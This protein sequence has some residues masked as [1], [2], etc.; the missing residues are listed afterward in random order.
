MAL[1]T[2]KERKELFP[3]FKTCTYLNTASTG[4]VPETAIAEQDRFM[5]F[6]R[7]ETIQSQPETFEVIE[8]IREKLSLILGAPA[9]DIALIN[10]TSYGINMTAWG[11]DFQKGDK[12]LIPSNEFPANF[13]PWKIHESRGAEIIINNESDEAYFDRKDAKVIAP[14]WIRFYDGF[15]F[16]LTH[17]VDI[18]KK[19]NSLVCVDGIQGAGV[20][21]PDLEKSGVD[22]FSA[23]GQKWLLSPYGTG[24]LYVRKDA[25]IRSLFQGW[26]QR[27][28]ETKDFSNVRKY[29]IPEP[30]DATR[31]EI[32]SLTYQALFAMNKSLKLINDLGIQNIE[33][34]ALK[35]ANYFADECEQLGFRVVSPGGKRRS[36]IIS[37]HF[38]DSKK[39]YEAL[40]QQK[41]LCSLREGNI[42]FSFHLYNN[43]EDVEKTLHC[44]R[45]LFKDVDRKE[46]DFSIKPNKEYTGIYS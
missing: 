23:G 34:H 45:E 13:Y 15:R 27:F 32:G 42:R 3:I 5:N 17:C 4:V 43:E 2:N 20:L 8:Q 12:I 41:V 7:G 9:E 35:L 36:A 38:Q 31:F 16:D 46:V 33:K 37:V 39:V 26:L 21:Y 18:A 24:V 25:P 1:L 44:I 40:L 28:L 29:D 22:T 19:H 6:Y 11:I 14:S 30:V 10:N